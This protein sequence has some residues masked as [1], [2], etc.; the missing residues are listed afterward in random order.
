MNLITAGMLN[1]ARDIR[2]FMERPIEIDP[3]VMRHA[4]DL[5]LHVELEDLVKKRV[6]R[7]VMDRMA[8]ILK[9]ASEEIKGAMDEK[10]KAILAIMDVKGIWIK[11]AGTVAKG[12]RKNISFSKETL[13]KELLENGV[14]SGVIQSAMEKAESTSPSTYTTFRWETGNAKKKREIGDS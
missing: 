5:N 4:T 3:D 14:S 10:L 8:K 2:Y 12:S 9:D 7:A 6:M 11:D 13:I 1:A